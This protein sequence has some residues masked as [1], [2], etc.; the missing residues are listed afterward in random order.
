MP[1]YKAVYNYLLRLTGGEVTKAEDL[2]QDVF[3]QA[4][5]H[6]DKFSSGTNGR[7]W[8]FKIAYH[9]FVNEWRRLRRQT[10]MELDER[11][12]GQFPAEER[13]HLAE[14]EEIYQSGALD[15]TFSDRVAACL[16]K[17]S[18]GQRSLILMADLLDFS[19]KEIAETTST[20]LNTVKSRMRYAL[21][22]LQSQL[23]DL[24]E[25]AQ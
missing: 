13:H 2:T 22:R 9:G 1:H 11:S 7:A 4:F 3:I 6:R 5:K 18:A 16:A 12:A 14:L 20:T 10:T 23:S 19:E 15:G 25:S 8:L 21:E 24:R 17:L